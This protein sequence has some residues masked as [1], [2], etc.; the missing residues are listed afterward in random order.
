MCGDWRGF[1]GRGLV[2]SVRYCNGEMEVCHHM[3]DLLMGLLDLVGYLLVGVGKVSH[4]LC[5]VGRGL[6][7]GGG[8]GG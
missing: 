2:S 4:R 3:L 7:V 8:S 5:L 6:A 1:L